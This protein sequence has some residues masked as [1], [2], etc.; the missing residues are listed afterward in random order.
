MVMLGAL[1]AKSGRMSGTAALSA[2]GGALK[3]WQEGNLQAYTEAAQ[4][5]KDEN[6]RTI[7]NNRQLLEK[8][9]MVLNDHRMNIDQQ[10][11]ALQR[12]A[13]EDHDDIGYRLAK[14][15]HMTAIAQRRDM[16]WEYTNG[17]KGIALRA[18]KIQEPLD[19][20]VAELK[21][22]ALYWGPRMQQL[23]GG[24][25]STAF[26][27]Q[28]QYAVENFG[29]GSIGF[30]ATGVK[31]GSPDALVRQENQ[32]RVASGR[33]IMTAQETVQFLQGLRPPRSVA[34][35]TLQDFRRD[36]RAANEGRDPSAQE[37]IQWQ[38]KQGAMAKTM[39]DFATGKQG[40]LVTSLN[41]AVSHI[42][43][44]REM[45]RALNNGN[46]VMFNKIAQDWAAQTGNPVPTNFDMAK[47]IVAKEINKALVAGGG[48]VTERQEFA[49]LMDKKW[50]PEQIEGQADTA[51][52]L[53]AGQFRGLKQ[54]YE[55][56]TGMTDF[57]T[58]MSDEALAA[59]K[60]YPAKGAGGGGGG[61]ETPPVPNARKAPDGNWYID[62]PNRPGKYLKVG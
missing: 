37:E 38:A 32:E 53:L 1:A 15:G 60:K 30:G 8:Y 58:K 51:E 23:E 12:N 35:Q 49:T 6:T 56:N 27:K 44:L 61:T 21:Q 3:G 2:F 42:N 48:G 34:G 20:Q 18:A 40:Q 13:V 10:L 29:P 41:V 57:E 11:A 4:K 62:D 16:L 59:Y 28:V 46:T 14:E 45:G 36:Y 25:Y 9:D 22:M 55:A 17:E 7:E 19:K 54:Q 43:T 5:W 24:P 52:T 26:K 31:A 33:Q 47:D 50:G 39:K